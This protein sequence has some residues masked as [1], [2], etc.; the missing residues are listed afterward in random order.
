MVG[1]NYKDEREAAISWL[2]AFGNPYRWVLVDTA[3]DVAIDWGVYGVPETFVID[4][5]GIIRYK[6][7]GPLDRKVLHGKIF[8]LVRQL[9][10]K[11]D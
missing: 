3:G 1:L 7:I 9:S 2:N 6:H 11:T 5:K 8:P 10:Q 4:A